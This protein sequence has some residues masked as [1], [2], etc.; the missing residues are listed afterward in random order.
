MPTGNHAVPETSDLGQQI[1]AQI[2]ASGPM[3]LSTYM[4]LCLTHPTL[5]YYKRAD[6]LGAG[7]DFVTAPEISQM[8]GEIIGLW[9]ANCWRTMGMPPRFDLVELGPGRGTLMDDAL[10]VLSR[11]EG[12]TEAMRLVLVETN[13]AL[14]AAQK[15]R[16]ARY[17]PKWIAEIDQLDD[18][19]APLIIIANEFF[20]ALPIKQ[21]QKHQGQWHERAIG[22]R[23]N[24]RAWGLAP[25]PL[26]SDSLPPAIRKAA[27][28]E[29]WEA[30]LV[31]QEV[32]ADIA[33]RLAA[34]TG[35]LLAIDYGYA[36]TQTGDTFQAIEKHQFADPLANPGK[37]DLTA[38]VDFEALGRAANAA[39]ANALPLMTQ[40]QFLQI[41]GINER[42]DSLSK[43]NPGLA[44]HIAA[45]RDRLVA[46]D[47]MGTLFK[48]LCVASPGLTPYPFGND[49]PDQA[50]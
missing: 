17:N 3:S 34:R 45:A 5:G 7:G 44:A 18:S 49:A 32:M 50:Q 40:A 2:R 16:L 8:F 33:K 19:D 48:V 23:D 14:I 21:F 25:T 27:D 36:H 10:R 37:A 38:H 15:Q 12:A 9:I 35:A 22:L 11:V 31:A 4:R 43:A 39:G 41:L 26:P 6:P 30:G 46:G 47:Q 13:D 42:V 20:D 24:K 28:G 29:V 1:D